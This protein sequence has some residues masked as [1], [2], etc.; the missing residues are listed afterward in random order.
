[1]DDYLSKP[2]NQAQLLQLL[3]KWLPAIVP[4]KMPAP[5][6]TSGRGLSPEAEKNIDFDALE[7]LYGE[8]DLPHLIDSFLTEGT[9]L[10][11]EITARLEQNDF[12]E[13]TRLAHQLKGLA[14][15][16]TG[17]HLAGLAIELEGQAKKQARARTTELALDIKEELKKLSELIAE[18]K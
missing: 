13:I 17:S 10:L 4:A 18:R 5:E 6:P 14:V 11:T 9:E 7:R 12:G 8:M 16:M 15:V 3:E 2:V 1:M